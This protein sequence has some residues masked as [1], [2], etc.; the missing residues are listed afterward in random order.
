MRNK[1]YNKDVEKV[2]YRHL[3][4]S[5]NNPTLVTMKPYLKKKEEEPSYSFKSS[6][7]QN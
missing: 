2:Q 1:V 7:V 6:I 4:S 3:H 5:T